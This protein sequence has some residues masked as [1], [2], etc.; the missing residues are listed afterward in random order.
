MLP[1]SWRA[2][3]HG[4]QLRASC[5]RVSLDFGLAGYDRPLRTN[6]ETSVSRLQGAKRVLHDPVLERVEGDY[7]QP[8]LRA[9]APGCLRQKRVEAVKL[10]IHPDP[11]RLKRARRGIDSRIPAP[12]NGPP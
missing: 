3:L 11:N 12:R 6:R 1:R 9:Q 2:P 5:A 7:R 4:P 10:A 8:A